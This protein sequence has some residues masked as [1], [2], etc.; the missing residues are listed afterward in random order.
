VTTIKQLSRVRL[1]KKPH[2]YKALGMWSVGYS[3]PHYRNFV[4]YQH[5]VQQAVAFMRRLNEQEVK[6]LKLT[7]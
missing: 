7:N 5:K 6:N 3:R 4:N 1:E 2:I